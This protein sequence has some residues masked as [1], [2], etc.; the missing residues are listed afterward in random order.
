MDISIVPLKKIIKNKK[1][2]P[3]QEEEYT[4]ITEYDLLCKNNIFI[5]E[6][7]KNIIN[8]NHFFIVISDIESV[9]IIKN[10]NYNNDDININNF[11]NSQ[12]VLVKYDLNNYNT[13]SQFFM[14]LPE[15]KLFLYHIFDSYQYLL[16]SLYILAENNI[17]FLDFT[18][19]NIIFDNTLKPKIIN[20]ELTFEQNI[21]ISDLKQ[22]FN[23]I[24]NYSLK[25]LEIHLLFNLINSKI[26]YITSDLINEIVDYFIENVEFFNLFSNNYKKQ[27]REESIS[28]LNNFV[29]KP[30]EYIIDEI[31]KHKHT[32]ANY[33]L[34]ILYL[35]LIG[36]TIKLMGLKNTIF[37]KIL[38]ILNKNI[39][40][41]PKKREKI[42]DTIDKLGLLSNEHINWDF[43]KNCDTSNIIYEKLINIFKNK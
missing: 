3:K 21:N 34:S 27:Y 36:N 9:K 16:N 28:Y 5:C 2:T 24:K 8:F 13:F 4:I 30:S 42:N 7:I 20:F 29:N 23:K 14:N 17:Y 32:W 31:L 18:N 40:P 6:K 22:F 33:S 19:H 39:N 15:I 41:N 38:L 35:F 10:N 1:I 11:D 25:P 37:N 12:Y 26:K 43:I